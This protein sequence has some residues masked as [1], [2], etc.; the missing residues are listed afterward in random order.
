M[1][2]SRV[3]LVRSVPLVDQRLSSVRACK[4]ALD[5]CRR[6]AGWRRLRSRSWLTAGALVHCAHLHRRFLRVAGRSR[7]GAEGGRAGCRGIARGGFVRRAA[8]LRNDFVT[9][10]DA[11]VG[12]LLPG[13]TET[14]DL[15]EHLGVF[16]PR[17]MRRFFGRKR[18]ADRL[19]PTTSSRGV[20]APAGACVASEGGAGARA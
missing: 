16:S 13:Q 14:V 5:L 12:A 3:E 20:G 1:R 7:F 19:D 10:V 17:P 15:K 11:L 9:S 2:R 4:H 8:G 6:C 18:A